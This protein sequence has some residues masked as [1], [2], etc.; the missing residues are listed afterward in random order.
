MGNP[1]HAYVKNIVKTNQGSTTLREN[2][3]P[4]RLNSTTRFFQNL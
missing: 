2:A 1:R 3:I 4:K